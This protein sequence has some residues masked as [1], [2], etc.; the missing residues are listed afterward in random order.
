MNNFID[1]L[2]TWGYFSFGIFLCFLLPALWL[3]IVIV[4]YIFGFL[5]GNNDI[6]HNFLDN[7]GYI[8]TAII[9]VVGIVFWGLVVIVIIYVFFFS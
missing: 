4:L 2:L 9:N 7:Y 1:W 5:S 8:F 6:V 3:F